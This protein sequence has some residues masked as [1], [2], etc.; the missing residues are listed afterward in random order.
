MSSLKRQKRNIGDKQ[1]S[2]IRVC[3]V[4]GKQ[5]KYKTHLIQYGGNGVHRYTNR[6]H[7]KLIQN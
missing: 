4:H 6:E 1:P 3:S 2:L 7:T 5:A